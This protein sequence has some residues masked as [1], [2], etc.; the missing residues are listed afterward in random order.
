MRGQLAKLCALTHEEPSSII[1][2]M[3]RT[4]LP[5]T[6]LL[7]LM[8]FTL[9]SGRPKSDPRMK[10]ADRDPERNGWITVHLSGSPAEIGYQH[11]YLLAAEIQ[12]NFKA[13]SVEMMHDEKKDW[14]F[15]R[16]A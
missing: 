4:L 14:S 1:S 6:A 10:T 2:A 15:F 11:G 3:R 8:A 9:L 7:L 5:F 12:D 13:I 16:N